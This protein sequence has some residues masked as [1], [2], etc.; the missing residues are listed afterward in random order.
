MNGVFDHALLCG[1]TPGPLTAPGWGAS[2]TVLGPDARQGKTEPQPSTR[3]GRKG[4]G[5]PRAGQA[6]VLG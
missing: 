6:T 2:R 3:L 1:Q 5:P 4:H